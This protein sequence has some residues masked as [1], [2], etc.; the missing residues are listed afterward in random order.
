M[1]MRRLQGCGPFSPKG[2]ANVLVV[3][4][5]RGEFTRWELAITITINIEKRKRL[6]FWVNRYCVGVLA[7]ATAVISIFIRI[8]DFCW[9]R[10]YWY[11][12]RWNFMNSFLILLYHIIDLWSS[13]FRKRGTTFLLVSSSISIIRVRTMWLQLLIDCRNPPYVIANR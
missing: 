4:R 11:G 10:K 12:L 8:L 7:Y 13:A 2:L 1:M 5:S 9:K 6:L 3:R